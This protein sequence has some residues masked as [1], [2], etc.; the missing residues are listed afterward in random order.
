MTFKLFVCMLLGWITLSCGELED[1]KCT[2]SAN[3]EEI[4]VIANYSLVVDI[5]N[6]TINMCSKSTACQCYQNIFTD[7]TFREIK[8]I[9]VQEGVS[10]NIT[11]HNG[12]TVHF[13]RRTAEQFTSCTFN[14]NATLPDFNISTD[15]YQIPPELLNIG[16]NLFIC[17][18]PH[19]S[20]MTCHKGCRL[21]ITVKENTCQENTSQIVCSGNGRCTS[22][23]NEKTFTCK[24]FDGF[25]GKM[26]D[27]IYTDDNISS[28]C[29][30]NKC[31]NGGTC[32][33]ETSEKLSIN[34]STW[35]CECPPYVTGEYCET[36]LNQCKSSP[37]V[38]GVCVEH[39]E[40]F[41]CYCVPGFHGKNCELEY[42][43][44]L[45]NPCSNRGTCIDRVD[46]F[47]CVCSVGYRGITCQDKIDMCQ[48]NPCHANSTCA[49]IGDVFKCTCLNGFTGNLCDERMKSCSSSPCKNH[50]TCID[51]ENG[52]QCMCP[53][54]FAGLHCEYMMDVF[55]PPMEGAELSG[56]SHKHNMYIVAATLGS[57]LLIVVS[58]IIACYCKIYETYKQL[59][60]KRLRYHRE[61]S[62]SCPDLET[63]NEPNYIGKHR[64]S[65]DAILEA[66]SLCHENAA[67]E[68]SSNHQAFTSMQ[69]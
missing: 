63:C 9:A 48:P 61:R 18:D 49:T 12:R 40:G 42:N 7:D 30:D 45:S 15:V 22:A 13:Y 59:M 43:E 47:E 39:A 56:E 60:W 4:E 41:Q 34:I 64:L 53:V 5:E 54:T 44:C 68:H 62:N 52:Y 24:C 46:R 2:Y 33:T 51:F 17:D 19:D 20:N 27:L 66:T 6:K 11:T 23:F 14:N 31:R 29:E 32:V 67:F 35:K 57:M 10:V 55:A 21:N 8:P 16:S 28:V 38:N 1:V 25:G 69:I 50:G 26:C 58:V 65:A 37:C 36:I 3:N